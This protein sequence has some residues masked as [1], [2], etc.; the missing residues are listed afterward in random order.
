MKKQDESLSIFEEKKS[1]KLSKV[2][3]NAIYR[4]QTFQYQ[5]IKIYYKAYQDLIDNTLVPNTILINLKWSGIKIF[6]NLFFTILLLLLH[7][8][9]FIR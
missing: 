6:P 4:K 8:Y 5:L 2:S 9:I 3:R 1:L 7:F